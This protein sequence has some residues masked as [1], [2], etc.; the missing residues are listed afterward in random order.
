MAT[1]LQELAGEYSPWKM[2][3]F[4]LCGV[5]L[6]TPLFDAANSHVN[7]QKG[8][9]LYQVLL[10]ASL[11]VATLP[12]LLVG[13][14]RV[15]LFLMIAFSVYYPVS[16]LLEQLMLSWLGNAFLQWRIL[17]ILSDLPGLVAGVLLSFFVFKKFIGPVQL[18]QEHRSLPVSNH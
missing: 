5:L 6:T 3:L 16:W 11:W 4:I 1:N 14:K 18:V 8:T 10:V 2:V 17:E 9:L 12:M 7:V 15:W 13:D